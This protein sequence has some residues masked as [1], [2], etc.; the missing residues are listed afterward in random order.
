MGRAAMKL[1]GVIVV[2]AALSACAGQTMFQPMP[3]TKVDIRQ[4][5]AE[6]RYEVQA[7]PMVS[8]VVCMDRK[9]WRAAV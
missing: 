5:E 2:C 7:N 6:C 9:G 8:F 1:C 3:W 4:A